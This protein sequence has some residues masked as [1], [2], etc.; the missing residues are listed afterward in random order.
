MTRGAGVDRPRGRGYLGAAAT[1]PCSSGGHSFE[2]TTYFELP[3]PLDALVAVV[4]V[5]EAAE[6]LPVLGELV[7]MPLR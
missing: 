6:W 2:L 4:G 3:Q 5:V 1:R 7:V